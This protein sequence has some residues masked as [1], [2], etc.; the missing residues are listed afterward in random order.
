MENILF[1][2]GWGGDENSFA[3]VLPY[4]RTKYNCICVAM[5]RN[6][7]VTW[8]LDDYADFVRAELDRLGVR[9]AHIICHSFGARVAV[10]LVTAQPKRFGALVMSG[11]AGL[12]RRFNLWVWLRIR[13]HKMGI[14]RGK[15]SPDYRVLS[16]AGKITFQNIIKRDL[17][18]EIARIVNPTLLIW[19]EKDTAIKKYMVKRWT[20][21]NTCTRL[22]TYKNSGHFCFMDS[23]A[24]FIID[25]E[26][27]LDAF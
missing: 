15:G 6:Q 1:L 23:P 26:E 9:K 2:H 11:P 21:L 8:T 17:S 25:V 5:P 18:P 13:L 10:L 19:G 20:K 22:E 24:K 14:I 4:F 7:D 27:F 16:R 3:S 12:R